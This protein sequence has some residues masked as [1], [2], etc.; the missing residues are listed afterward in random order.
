MDEEKL[1]RAMAALQKGNGDALADVYNLTSKGVFTFVLPIL[2]DYQLSEDV[3]QETYVTC[4]G[5]I[6]SYKLGTNARNW[7]LTIAKNCALSQLKKR[8]RE[9]SYD[10]GDDNRPDGVY[11]LGEI[12]SP[13]I[14][15]ANKVLAED[16]FNIVMMY[17]I[18]EYKHKEIAEF[19][20]MPLGTVTWKYATALKKLKKA[21]EDNKTEY[22]RAHEKLA[23]NH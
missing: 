2:R 6:Q 17:A 4:Y 20:H 15:L 12:D 9:V 1:E 14:T 23:E 19:L 7:L 3:M 10:F 13:T 22:E 11:Y 21:I 8:N 5:S 18:G 16:E